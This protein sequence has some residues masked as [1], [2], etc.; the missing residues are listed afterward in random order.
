M[1][2][3]LRDLWQCPM[4][5]NRFV[6]KNMWHSCGKFELEVL[7]SRSEPNVFRLYKRFVELVQACRPV[8]I[9]PRK[10]RVAFQV[11][12]RF[13]GAIPRKSYL[14]C[15]F[16]FTR[17]RD[18]PRFR[19]ITKYAPRVYGHQVRVE[20]EDEFDEEFRSWIREAYEVGQQKHLGKGVD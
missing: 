19:K 16:W 15:G 9:I 12:V 20:S 11:R 7:S 4:C 10:T 17:R 5:G 6:T 8:T 18:H 3:K 13:A 14:L 1:E 2:P